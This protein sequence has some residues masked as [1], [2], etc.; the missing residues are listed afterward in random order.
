M[1]I[2]QKHVRIFTDDDSSDK[3][4]ENIIEELPFTVEK[5][6]LHI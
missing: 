2:V 3:D 6:H 4:S 1:P 5:H